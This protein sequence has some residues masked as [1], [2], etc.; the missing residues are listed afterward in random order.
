MSHGLQ[1]AIVGAGPSGLYTAAGLLDEGF[2]VDLLERLPTPFGLVR[3]GVAP[4]H[5][6]I[7]EV[8][9]VYERI[10]AHP[11]FRFFGGISLGRHVRHDELIDRYHA[12]VYAVGAALDRPL[13]IPGEDA[14]GSHT[15]AEFIGWYNGDPAHADASFPLDGERAVVIGNGNVAL[16]VARMLVL[17]P[18][19]LASTDTADHA[20][21]AL[22]R[23]SVRE[24][25]VVGRRGPAQAA[26]TTPELRE[27]GRLARAVWSWSQP[28]PNSTRRANDG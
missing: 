12:V 17:A 25:I 2:D 16:D 11:R 21:A 10:A 18:D 1:A 8:S 14:P 28:T 22:A 24:V 15:A 3:Y 23:S 13:A 9:R 6:K 5:P 20:R 7:K 26:F 27:L 4:D 19:Q